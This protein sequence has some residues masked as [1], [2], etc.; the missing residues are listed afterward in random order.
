MGGKPP[1][2]IGITNN[3][4]IDPGTMCR[5]ES[6]P[7]GPLCTQLRPYPEHRDEITPIARYIVAE[8]NNNAHG[9]DVKKMAEMNNFSAEA[10]IAD[11]K[12]LPL[13]KQLLG[14][15]IQPDQCMDIQLSY[16]TAH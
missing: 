4:V 14:P 16:S 3:P 7:S 10:C 6:S 11:F 1:G 5:N 13:W 15:G 2:P 9:V 8:M 12:Q